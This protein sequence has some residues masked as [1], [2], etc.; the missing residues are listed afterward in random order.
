MFIINSFSFDIIFKILV[1]YLLTMLSKKIKIILVSLI[2]ATLLLIISGAVIGYM[3]MSGSFDSYQSTQITTEVV[4]GEKFTKDSLSLH[5]KPGDCYIAYN[6]T[7][8]NVSN[9]KVWG[10][11]FHGGMKGGIDVTKKFPHPISY[12]DELP[13][14]GTYS[15]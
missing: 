11:C 9:H 12:F 8:Y 4:D 2:L 14:M 6:G 7:I 15:E 5:N 1:H 10:T 13:V 3:I